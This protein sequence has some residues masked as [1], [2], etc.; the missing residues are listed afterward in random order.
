MIEELDF[1]ILFG[2][3]FKASGLLLVAPIYREKGRHLLLVRHGNLLRIWWI[4]T[5]L[6]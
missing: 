6:S 2:H 1:V 4:V 5:D 3:G